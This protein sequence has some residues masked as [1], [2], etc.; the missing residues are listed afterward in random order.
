M[1]ERNIKRDQE[2][3]NRKKPK[4]GKEPLTKQGKGV[5][6]KHKKRGQKSPKQEE[7]D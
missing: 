1:G 6:E 5:G 2:C 7:S 3:K 4:Q